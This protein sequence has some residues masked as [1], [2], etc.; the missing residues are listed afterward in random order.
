MQDYFQEILFSTIISLTAKSLKIKTRFFKSDN[1]RSIENLKFK[2]EWTNKM[3]E[4][5]LLK[6]LAFNRIFK[7]I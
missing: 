4:G 1:L 6:Y 2:I 3:M 5:S 7:T